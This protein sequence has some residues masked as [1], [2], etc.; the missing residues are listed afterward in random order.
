MFQ[1]LHG[2]SLS[3]HFSAQ[4][5]VHSAQVRCYWPHMTR[6]IHQGCLEC[7]ACEARR[8]QIPHQLTLTPRGNR[9]V[10]VVTDYFTKYLN[11]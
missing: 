8:P 5:A 6:D 1:T 11:L 3:G 9:Y 7:T 4:K 10:L 2:H